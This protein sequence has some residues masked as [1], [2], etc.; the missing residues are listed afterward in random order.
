MD[1]YDLIFW[2]SS[3]DRDTS[4]EEII[5]SMKFPNDIAEVL[6]SYAGAEPVETRSDVENFMRALF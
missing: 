1:N 4:Q 2:A 3:Y 6:F 5:K